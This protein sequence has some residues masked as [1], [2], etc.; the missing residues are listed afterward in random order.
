MSRLSC[1]PRHGVV[2]ATLAITF[3]MADAAGAEPPRDMPA[4]FPAGAAAFAEI[5]GLGTKLKE[6]R[7]SDLWTS[8]LASPQYKRYEG[9]AD[10]RKLQAGLLIA[11]GQLGQDPLTL[12]ERMLAGNVA[13]AVYHK[14][15]DPKPDALAI[16]RTAD[17][18]LLAALRKQLDPLIT[19]AADQIRRTELLGGVEVFQLPGDKGVLAWKEDWLAA[20]TNRALLDTA[21]AGLNGDAKDK[22]AKSFADDAPYVNMVKSSD[23][24]APAGQAKSSRAFRAFVDTA[25]IRKAAGTAKIPTKL[26][27]ALSSLLFGDVVEL[28]STSPFATMTIDVADR[29]VSINSS[30]ARDAEKVAEPFRA[31]VPAGEFGVAPLPKL[32]TL[33]SGFTLYRDFADWYKHRE[34][35]L[36]EQ[37]MPEFDKFESGLANLLPGRDFGSDVLPLLGKRLTF[38]AAPQ[39]YSHL[40]GE[41]GVKLPGMAIIVELAKPEEGAAVL[42]LFYQTIAAILNLQAGQ[43]GRQPWVVASESYRDV[44]VSFAKYLEKPQG[45]ELGIVANFLPSSACVGNYF[46][47]SS[48]LPLCKQLIDATKDGDATRSEIKPPETMLTEVK[49][50][51]LAAALKSNADFFVARLAQEGRSTS[52]AQAEFAASLDLLQRFDSLRAATEISPNAYTLRIEGTWK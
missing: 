13:V 34:Y 42:Q 17:R 7:T 10:Y 8:F 50:D 6:F 25:L 26:D 39:D 40:N 44:Q 24:S 21:I 45:K 48:S 5:S 38:V 23:W 20:A 41:P 2:V 35:L 51:S 14:A 47:L 30:L 36:Q 16:V 46:V 19:L 1:R 11:K 32:P 18:E 22:P 3:L 4:L 43:E 33:I 49:F 28:L 52:E 9:S 12:V 31:F 27:N 15:G 37:I 29:G